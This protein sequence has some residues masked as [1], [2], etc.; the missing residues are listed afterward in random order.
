MYWNV[1]VAEVRR[2]FPTSNFI[3]DCLPNNQQYL[4]SLRL[5]LNWRKRNKT[6][7]PFFLIK[8]SFYFLFSC[9]MHS[10]F[11]FCSWCYCAETPRLLETPTNIPEIVTHTATSLIFKQS[12][13]TLNSRKVEES[14][15]NDLIMLQILVTQTFRKPFWMHVFSNWSLLGGLLLL[16]VIP[17]G[18]IQGGAVMVWCHHK[19]EALC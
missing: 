18:G 9:E 10:D 13:I 15:S 16:L 12:P 11:R 14:G 17:R 7:F 3:D 1:G 8:L 5:H 6:A 4:Q 19:Q 2:A